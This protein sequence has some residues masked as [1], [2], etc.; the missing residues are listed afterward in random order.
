[1]KLFVH[2]FVPGPRN[3]CHKQ[4]PYNTVNSAMENSPKIHQKVV[5][6]ESFDTSSSNEL[7]NTC[8]VFAQFHDL[9]KSHVNTNMSN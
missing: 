4:Q 7:Y 8:S 9:C 6:Y 5:F 3:V 1:M 2:V